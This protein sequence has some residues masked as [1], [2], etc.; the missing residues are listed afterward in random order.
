MLIRILALLLSFPVVI[1][2]AQPLPILP[3]RL[4]D[5]IRLD[6]IMNEPVCKEIQPIINKTQTPQVGNDLLNGNWNR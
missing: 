5:P 6:G 1:T 2:S 4:S 3:Q